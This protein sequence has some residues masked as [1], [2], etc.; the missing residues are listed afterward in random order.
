MRF[1]HRAAGAGRDIL[2]RSGPFRCR[3]QI[4]APLLHT[5]IPPRLLDIAAF[6]LGV[7]M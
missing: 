5:R 6:N 1:C 7:I 2:L 4:P 3:Q